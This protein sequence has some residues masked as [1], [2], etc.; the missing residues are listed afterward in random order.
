MRFEVYRVHYFRWFECRTWHEDF[1][2]P[3]YTIQIGWLCLQWWSK[4]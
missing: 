4:E 2:S 1:V 3:V